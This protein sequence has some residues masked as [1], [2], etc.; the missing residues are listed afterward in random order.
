MKSFREARELMVKMDTEA[1]EGLNRSKVTIKEY[2]PPKGFHALVFAACLGTYILLSRASNVA[3]GSFL[4]E[5]VPWFAAYVGRI[6]EWVLYPMIV[7]HWGEAYLMTERMKKHS[8]PTFS[9]LWWTWVI[10]CF[11]EGMGSFQRYVF[12]T[13]DFNQKM[14]TNKSSD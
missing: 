2:S 3:P 5:Y 4:Y 1:L 9:R 8:V 7:L 12:H 14:A 6:R 11:I 13:I 10:S